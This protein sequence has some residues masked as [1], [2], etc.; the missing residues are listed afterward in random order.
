[1]TIIL[2][3]NVPEK[4][5]GECTRYLLEVKT[6]VFLGNISKVVRDILW[7]H[8]C[9]SCTNGNAV[10]A[11]SASNEQSFELE[12]YGNPHYRVIDLDGIK[13]IQHQ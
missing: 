12:M 3:E 5:R 1:M 9:K 10:M 6:G 2:M 13:L 4:I 11:Y 8:I 7:E